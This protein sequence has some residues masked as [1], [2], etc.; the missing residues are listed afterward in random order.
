MNSVAKETQ[1][2]GTKAGTR[3]KNRF[4]SACDVLKLDTYLA[5]SM[6]FETNDLTHSGCHLDDAWY[7]ENQKKRQ[8]QR[9]RER[10]CGEMTATS[11]RL[12]RLLEF[13]IWCDFNWANHAKYFWQRVAVVAFFLVTRGD[14][15]NS[16]CGANSKLYSIFE[17]IRACPDHSLRYSVK[18][19]TNSGSSHRLDEDAPSPNPLRK[20]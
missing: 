17:R 13:R 4:L 14:K 7:S 11:I 1:A 19:Q 6:L 20:H 16:R 15:W 9:Q 12:L 18:L 8:R 10:K 5:V 2:A 3:R